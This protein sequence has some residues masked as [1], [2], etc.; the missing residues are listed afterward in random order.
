MTIAEKIK[1]DMRTATNPQIKN[2]YRFLVGELDRVAKN[3]S[4]KQT[5]QVLLML[6]KGVEENMAIATANIAA[7]ML[8]QSTYEVYL[9]PQPK[10]LSQEE[11][12]DVVYKS[13]LT[14]LPVL[15][16]FLSHYEKENFVTID[17]A[18]ARTLL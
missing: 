3:P 7:L 13:E 18:F 12:K 2:I 11:I 9:P 6:L 14:K 10:V 5:E 16:A 8:E 4:D 15:M 1:Q 17:K